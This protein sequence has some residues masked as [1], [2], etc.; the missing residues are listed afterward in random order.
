MKAAGTR[1]FDTSESLPRIAEDKDVQTMWCLGLIYRYE[2]IIK[3]RSV[4]MISACYVNQKIGS[5]ADDTG[6][7]DRKA[8]VISRRGVLSYDQ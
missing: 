8:T 6:R 2:A 3:F 1:F 7:Q 5:R 4:L